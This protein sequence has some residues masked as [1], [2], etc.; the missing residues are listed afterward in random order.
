MN[1]LKALLLSI[2]FTL[3]LP[4]CA[5]VNKG[6][7]DFFRI[8][9][10]PQ[11]AAVTT[12]VETG[13]SERARRKN[14]QLEPVYLGC[15]PTPCAIKLNRRQNF[16]IKLEHPNFQTAEMYITN[17][18]NSASF[19]GNM[20]ATTVT[21]AGTMAAGATVAA[22]LATTLSVIST[23]T[24]NATLAGGVTLGTFG[25]VPIEASLAATNSLFV[26]TSVS[27]G[28]AMV[29]AIPPALA[30]TGGMLLVDAVSGA[31]V[32]L[33]PNPVV[34]ELAPKGV[35]TKIDPNVAS[36][37]TEISK[38]EAGTAECYK[39]YKS[40]L[41]RQCLSSVNKEYYATRKQRLKKKEAKAKDERQQ[42][43]TQ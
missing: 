36:F 39:K 13:A 14:P 2:F 29:A 19:T 30:V 25:L 27:T 7:S 31:N 34:L 24:A 37:K 1:S 12:T 3:L 42:Q 33:F 35:P 21:T 43:I 41:R 22:G 38:R 17:S 5:T 28:S 9:S 10:V 4:A 20:A 11:G 18:R 15:S 26:P 32:N 40:K 16:V 8:D 6:T 23:A